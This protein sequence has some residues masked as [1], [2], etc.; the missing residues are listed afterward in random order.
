MTGVSGSG[1]SSLVSQVLPTLVGEHLGRPI[2]ADEPVPDGDEMLLSDEPEELQGSVAGDLTGVRRVVS[3]DQKPIGRTP[4]SNVATYTGM[5]DHVRRRFAETPEA[6]SRGYKPGRF[7]FNVAGGRCPTCEGEGSVMVELLFLPSVYTECPDCHGTRYQASTLEIL[8]HGRNIAEILAMS[9]EEAHEFFEGEFDIMRSL[10]ALIDVG[11]GYLRLGQPATE[12]SGGEAQRVKLASELQR[13]QRGDTLYVLDE[14]T[15]GL[16][17]A[18]ADRL[19]TH[20][21][22]L[23]DAGNTVVMVELD[24]RVIA[25][26]D[27][28]ID[29]GPGAGDNGGQVVATGTPAE[30]SSSSE[31][32]SARYLAVA[33]E[34][35]AAVSEAETVVS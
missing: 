10:T 12:L 16:H 8:W 22:T 14:P 32:A 19:V 24:M 17:C 3:I 26:A 4:R 6:L 33:L 21:Q 5:F 13:A 20:M 27:H 34:E 28:V 7:S 9:V 23:V 11:L 15:S 18:D 35:T 31:S 29:L 25:E 30:V 1:K 2:Q